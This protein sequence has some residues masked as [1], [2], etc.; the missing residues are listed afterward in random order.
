MLTYTLG[1]LISNATLRADRDTSLTTSQVSLLVNEAYDEVATRLKYRNREAIAQS[2]L[3]DRQF[4]YAL[5]T[6]FEGVINAQIFYR[7]VTSDSVST[8][9]NDLYFPLRGRTTEWLNSFGT[10]VP[11]IPEA[12]VQYADWIELYP[13]P[14]LTTSGQSTVITQTLILK[15]VGQH[16][17]LL[18]LGDKPVLQPKWHP[19][20]LLKTVQK[21]FETTQNPQG[22]AVAEQRYIQYMSTT[23]PDSADRQMDKQSMGMRVLRYGSEGRY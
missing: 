3:T 2:D 13:P 15:Y 19:A 4:R 20:I 23:P 7:S 1:D 17:S 8:T 6:D 14:S 10:F 16:A 21:V 11:G 9:T 18:T 5:P 22:A 12:Y